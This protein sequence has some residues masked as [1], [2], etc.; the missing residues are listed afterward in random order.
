MRGTCSLSIEK[1]ERRRI[2]ELEKA[3]SNSLS[4]KTMFAAQQ[5]RIPQKTPPASENTVSQSL[6]EKD[7][8]EVSENKKTIKARAVQDLSELM[9]LKTEQLKKYGAVLIPQSNLYLKYQMVQSFLWMQLK[10]ETDNPGVTRRSLA[11]MVAQRFNRGW[12][13]GR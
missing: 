8:E 5:L 6:I 4:I 10:Q 1:R 12:Y 13:T 9:R 3:A 7:N 2:R 11:I